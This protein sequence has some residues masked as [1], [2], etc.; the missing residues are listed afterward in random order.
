MLRSTGGSPPYLPDSNTVTDTNEPY[1]NFL[2]YI[3][4]QK[5]IPSVISTSYGDDEQSASISYFSTGSTDC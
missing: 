5:N 2:E 3:S 1:L 4:A